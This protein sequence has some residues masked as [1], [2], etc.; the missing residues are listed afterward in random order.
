M[1]ALATDEFPVEER[2]E[3]SVGKTP[4]VRFD[5]NDRRSKKIHA[6]IEA[7]VSACQ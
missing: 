7:F 2:V 4:Y 6:A 3:V 5:K 1:I